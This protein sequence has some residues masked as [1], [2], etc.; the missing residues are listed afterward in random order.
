M[1]HRLYMGGA[2]SST[3]PDQLFNPI[4]SADGH[5]TTVPCHPRTLVVP[6]GQMLRECGGMR[7]SGLELICYRYTNGSILIHSRMLLHLANMEVSRKEIRFPTDCIQGGGFF[8][9]RT[10]Y[11][12]AETLTCLSASFYIF[13]DVAITATM[14]YCLY[15]S[16][17]GGLAVSKWLT[18]VVLKYTV[19][20]S[21]ATGSGKD[22][23]IGIYFVTAKVYIN[24][25]LA[26][27][28]SRQSLRAR[29]D[30]EFVRE[31]NTI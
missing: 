29:L 15:K 3:R 28:N 7:G 1:L 22:I 20:A 25:M 10:K 16:Q 5:L 23:Y 8:A 14:S 2:H 31:V 19:V 26:S 17:E 24:C 9:F 4:P 18:G 13:T 11:D 6:S 12:V 21:W 27:L 30:R